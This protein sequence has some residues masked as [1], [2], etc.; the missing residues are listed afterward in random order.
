[1]LLRSPM[2]GRLTG[3]VVDDDADGN[4]ILDVLGVGY[5]LT[6]PLGTLSQL[7]AAGGDVDAHKRRD[8]SVTLH[9]H[10]YIRQ[11]AL[12]LFGFCSALS[13]QVFR[14]LLGVPNIGPRLALSV[15]SVMTGPQL[16]RAVEAGDCLALVSV[17]GVGKKL[18]DR[19]VLE[20]K[21]KLRFALGGT[22]VDDVE[23]ERKSNGL[24]RGASSN[25]SVSV[26]VVDALVRMGYRH[27]EVERVVGSIGGTVEEQATADVIR[28][29]LALLSR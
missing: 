25:T 19:M 17:P 16:A 13:R 29:A 2:I 22:D 12:V 1:M 14:V 10:T 5:E 20:L 24:S 18:A 9:V 6:V 11:D 15:L 7:E 21:G 23:R 26:Q 4:V 27:A 28:E 3:V 8:R